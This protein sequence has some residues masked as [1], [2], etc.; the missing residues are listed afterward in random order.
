MADDRYLK[1][2]SNELR[3]I[4]RSRASSWRWVIIIAAGVFIGNIASFSIEKAVQYW[5]WNQVGNFFKAETQKMQIQSQKSKF[6]ESAIL[7]SQQIKLEQQRKQLEAQ[8]KQRQY[9]LQQKQQGL[10]QAQQ[11]CKFWTQQYAKENT[12]FN[13]SYRDQA[14]KKVNEF[15]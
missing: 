2:I 15:K 9:Q 11:T 4:E 8:T 10:R 7:K 1:E 14:C 3:Y 6:E 5:E 12:L 13:K